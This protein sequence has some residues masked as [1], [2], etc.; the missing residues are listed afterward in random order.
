MT[1]EELAS[2]KDNDEIFHIQQDSCELVTI[3]KICR[4][5]IVIIREWTNDSGNFC[6]FEFIKYNELTQ[7]EWQIDI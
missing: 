1:N 4:L 6:E 3:N 2:L 5:G 7:K